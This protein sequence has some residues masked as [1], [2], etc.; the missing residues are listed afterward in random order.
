MVCARADAVNKR[1]SG[2][3]LMRDIVQKLCVCVCV[4]AS[5]SAQHA[6]YVYILL[7]CLRHVRELRGEYQR[8]R[9]HRRH[10]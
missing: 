1:V 8:D 9:E 10:A 2:L 4:H 7:I 3:C 5:V 6:I